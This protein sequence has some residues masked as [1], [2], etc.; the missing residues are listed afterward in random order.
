[1]M[2]MVFEVVW[3]DN[4]MTAAQTS[5]PTVLE[6]IRLFIVASRRLRR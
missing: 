4:V 6:K 5:A 2:R 3:A 1:M